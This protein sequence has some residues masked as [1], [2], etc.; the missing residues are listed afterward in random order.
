MLERSGDRY[1]FAGRKGGIINVGGQKVHPEEVEGVI[2]RHP[3]V[4]MSLVQS[5]QEPDH[6][7]GRGG[8]GGAAG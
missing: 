2:N 5:A 1:H 7:R 6:G 4:R 8:R 3:Q